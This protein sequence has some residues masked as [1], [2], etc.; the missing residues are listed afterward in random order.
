MDPN[1]GIVLLDMN[2]NQPI[3]SRSLIAKSLVPSVTTISTA[4]QLNILFL[5]L[6]G[7][8]IQLIPEKASQLQQRRQNGILLC[9]SM[10]VGFTLIFMAVEVQARYQISFYI[11]WVLLAGV[12]MNGL[13]LLNERLIR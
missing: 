10:L 7:L 4:V 6:I 12:G 3:S 1:Y 2:T 13:A 11:P 9:A 8:S 5:V